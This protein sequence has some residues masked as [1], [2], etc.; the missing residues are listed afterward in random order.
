MSIIYLHPN[1]IE[2]L[3]NI[4]VMQE[5]VLL[6]RTYVSLF[7]VKFMCVMSVSDLDCADLQCL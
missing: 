1:T 5:S 4:Q 7:H 6:T 3:Q 2:P